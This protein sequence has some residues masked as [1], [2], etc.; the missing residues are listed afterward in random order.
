MPP[1]CG[2]R[3]RC[4]YYL[5]GTGHLLLE[6]QTKNPASVES[7]RIVASAAYLCGFLLFLLALCITQTDAGAQTTTEP[8]APDPAVIAAPDGKP[9]YY[10]FGTGG[11]I[12][13]ST[14][15]INWTYEGQVFE[16]LP[17]WA[18]KAVPGAT[19]YWAPDI[20]LHN[21]LYYLYYAV[22]TFGSQQSVIGLATNATIDPSD[23]NYQWQDRGLVI[24][25]LPG[26]EN[27]NAIDPAL[28]VDG[29]GRWRLFFGS[30][31]SG[32]KARGI[33]PR[34]GKL[35]AGGAI[36]SVAAR[37][38]SVYPDSIEGSYVIQH[39]DFYYL[40]VSWGSCCSGASSTYEIA[41]GRSKSASGP[42]VDKA[43]LRMRK[44][45][46][47]IVVAGRQPMDRART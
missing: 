36:E 19:I 16:Q 4:S 46:G 26:R 17:Q 43:G 47:T 28:F 41:V 37:A 3:L 24:K 32:I 9:G 25:S 30:F 2:R 14:D 34:T 29:K 40:F 44:G 11:G 12:W 31:W 13:F 22:S 23:P 18:Q 38:A 6:N 1:S 21:G 35:A 20:S 10:V 27:F 42:Y 7:A 45:G 15:L 8:P 5:S 33:N 39:G